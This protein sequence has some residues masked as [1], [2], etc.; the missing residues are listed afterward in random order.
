M[1]SPILFV[2]KPIGKGL[3]LCLD[4]WHLNDH[5]KKHETPLP[6]MDESSRKLG[7]ADFI[8]KVD[9]KAGLHL[10]RMAL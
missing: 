2:L 5:M 8:T 9:M 6:I 10:M 3:T 4:Y 1:G 7:E